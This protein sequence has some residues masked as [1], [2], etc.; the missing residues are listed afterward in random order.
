MNAVM[1]AEQRLFFETNGYLLIRDALSPEDLAE[2]RAAA[3]RA[4]QEW[5][6]NTSRLGE[7][8]EALQ[9][10]QAIIEYDPI[11]L[12]LMEHPRIFPII[13]EILGDD[14]AMVD[15]DYYISPPVRHLAR[16]HHW[17]FDEG[18]RGVYSPR[19]TMMV[20]VFYT[21]TDID[22]D[23]GATSFVP[24]SHRFPL[25]FKMPE[26][27]PEGEMPGSVRMAVPAGSAYLFSGRI[28]HAALPN[29]SQKTRRVL[30][31]NYGH[32]WMKPWQGY[33]PSA[34]LQA[35]ATTPVR[36]QLLHAVP[37]YGS[38]LQD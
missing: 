24:G 31:F 12:N 22:E 18:F 37:A 14:I 23:G 28:F 20:K 17:H 32:I 33:E 4:E 26:P 30:I 36:K 16:H 21:L 19:S 3:D 5:R 15:N 13:R 34:R 10:V 1:T 25:D 9:S 27:T 7:R 2:V 35:A 8:G 6:S 38:S 11:F 29:H